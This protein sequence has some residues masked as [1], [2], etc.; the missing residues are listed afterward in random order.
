MKQGNYDI[1]KSMTNADN[2]AAL[3]REAAQLRKP[4]RSV[5][6]PD[7]VD[8]HMRMARIA[9][10]QNRPKDAIEAYRKAIAALKAQEAATA[11]AQKAVAGK[12]RTTAEPP[13]GVVIRARRE[14]PEEQSMAL[15]YANAPTP[16]PPPPRQSREAVVERLLAQAE[17]AENIGKRRK[18]LRLYRE[19]AQLIKESAP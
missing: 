3:S 10:V 18:A 8:E 11:A 13:S 7:A 4:V 5:A 14:S 6:V 15:T 17:E 19:A 1:A 16:A 12:T 2:F 9:S